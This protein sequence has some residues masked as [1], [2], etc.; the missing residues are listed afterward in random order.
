MYAK[1]YNTLRSLLL[2]AA[3]FFMLAAGYLAFNGGASVAGENTSISSLSAIEPYAGPPHAR[4]L[5]EPFDE[6]SFS[7]NYLAARFAQ[8]H[9]Q[10]GKARTLLDTVLSFD[11]DNAELIKRSMILSMGSGDAQSAMQMARRLYRPG[12]KDN[13]PLIALFMAIDA[14]KSGDFKESQKRIQSVEPGTLSEFIAPLVTDWAAAGLGKNS[15]GDLTKNSIHVYH[16]ILIADYLGNHAHIESL[17]EKALKRTD[18]G[19][20]NLEKIADMYAHIGKKEDAL[21]HYRAALS[22]VP[23]LQGIKNKIADVQ[24]GVTHRIVDS[25]TSVHEGMAGAMYDMARLLSQEY[26]DETARIF[27]HLALY[28]NPGHHDAHLLLANISARNEK[29]EQAIHYYA[30]IPSSHPG[31]IEIRRKTANLLE[32][33]E[34][35]DEALTI[36]QDLTRLYEDV[37]AMVQI[38]DIH[39]RQENFTAAIRHYNKAEAKLTDAQKEQFWHLYYMRGMAHEQAG[40]WSHAEKDL[41]KALIYQPNHPFILNY[42]GYGWADQGHNL[43]E[44]LTMIR[45]AV[46]LRPTDGY[47]TDSLGWVFYKLGRFEEAIPHLE[48]AVELLPYDSV[49]NDHLGDAYWQVGRKLEARFQWVRARNYTEDDDLKTTISDK[50]ENGIPKIKP[51][52]PVI[53]EA[54]TLQTDPGTLNQ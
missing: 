21:K 6:T 7:G 10:W 46:S 17:L 49:I 9:D 25:V 38:G 45:K 34:R 36:L 3:A 20:E 4:L 24:E 54:S 32:D 8:N 39:R 41:Q 22:L 48:R 29:F 11:P 23:D 51:A 28:L 35:E 14:F 31:Y 19:P 1:G 26:S 16:A 13:E 43:S 12:G 52:L 18:I 50:L 53:K 2:S 27:A 47:I 37:E 42:L 33:A 44:A 30:Q 15:S 5:S 40:K